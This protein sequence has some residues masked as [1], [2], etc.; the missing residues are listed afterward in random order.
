[1]VK[2]LNIWY[3]WK[4]LNVLCTG[5]PDLPNG[6]MY[7][8]REIHKSIMSS[9]KDARSQEARSY[10]LFF[11]AKVPLRVVWSLGNLRPPC[12]VLSALNCCLLF[13]DPYHYVD[14]L[15][16]LP[17]YRKAERRQ[18]LIKEKKNKH[19]L[20]MLKSQIQTHMHISTIGPTMKI[21]VCFIVLCV[22]LMCLFYSCICAD[23]W[24]Q[25]MMLRIFWDAACFICSCRKYFSHP[26]LTAVTFIYWL[27]T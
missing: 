27:H 11:W 21:M 12:F 13:S 24:L 10:R 14:I 9:C 22:L 7:S 23:E 19:E 3:L 26:G 17:F 16:F 2:L 5:H 4:S 8:L 15:S 1:M 20:E 18:K 25:H 6:G